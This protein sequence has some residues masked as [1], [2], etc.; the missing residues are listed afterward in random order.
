MKN[1]FRT[2]FAAVANQVGFKISLSVGVILASLVAVTMT[3]MLLVPQLSPLL[4]GRVLLASVMASGFILLGMVLTFL[5]ANFFIAKPL[6]NLN[7]TMRQVESGILDVSSEPDTDDEFGLTKRHFNTMMMALKNLSDNRNQIEQRLVKAEESLKY[8][9][10]LEDKANIIARMN[11]ELTAA[12]NDITLLYTVSQNLN[13]VMDADRLVTTV[14]RIFADRFLCDGFALYLT[15]TAAA[16][17]FKI[18]AH[19]SLATLEQDLSSE[20]GLAGHVLSKKR[21]VYVDNTEMVPE[22][23]LHQ[24]ETAFHGSLYSA[25]LLV[26]G[27]VIGILTVCRYGAGG[28]MPTDR[29]SLESIASQIA[30]AHDRIELYTKTKELSVRD[31]L[32]GA[33]NRRHFM[34]MLNLEYKR[35]ERFGRP[36]SLMLIDVDHFKMFNDN[37]GHTKGDE[38]LRSLSQ[39]IMTNIR[40]VDLM[41]R[42]GGEE[43]VLMLPD[44]SY[45]DAMFVAAKIKKLVKTQLAN[46]IAENAMNT[47]QA[48]PD[49]LTT[50]PGV[51]ISVGVSTIPDS[52]DG[53]VSL[54]NSADLAMYQAKREGRD[55]VRGAAKKDDISHRRLA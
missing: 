9:L 51:T 2:I 18:V 26:R 33:Y 54:I 24:A 12:F 44:T 32:T 34:H 23:K 3:I 8:R 21:S 13:L 43:F 29:Q 30:V 46:F 14:N 1:P 5:I 47:L 35:A 38:L 22:L 48:L 36:L 6:A 19:K 40:E 11:R 10:A 55:L 15:K 45:E 25:P 31:E 37:F 49:R 27:E 41:A 42:Y 53:V 7:H 20:M 52:A 16:H 17:D 39:L 28:F 50:I 4:S